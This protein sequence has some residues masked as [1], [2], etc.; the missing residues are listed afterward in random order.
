MSLQLHK[1]YRILEVALASTALRVGLKVCM[2]FLM[3]TQELR[4]A[5]DVVLAVDFGTYV[6]PKH[7]IYSLGY[8]KS[9]TTYYWNLG[10]MPIGDQ[11]T[12]Y[13]YDS[14]SVDA[15]IGNLNSVSAN[16]SSSNS[17]LFL[18]E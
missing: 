14:V 12:I 8:S 4:V 18:V 1:C 15:T 7:G 6:I 9:G 16:I 5:D 3:E 13:V 11:N 10:S 17:E 2:P